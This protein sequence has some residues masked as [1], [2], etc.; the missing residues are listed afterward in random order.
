MFY[1]KSKEPESS[2]DEVSGTRI[3]KKVYAIQYKHGYPFFTFY[4]NGLWITRSAK[5]YIPVS[6]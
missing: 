5:H 4:E 6:D 3:K 1:V 2:C